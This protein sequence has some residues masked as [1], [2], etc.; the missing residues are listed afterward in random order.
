MKSFHGLS[1]FA[2]ISGFLSFSLLDSLVKAASQWYSALVI[3][4]YLRIYGTLIIILV[5]TTKSIFLRSLQPYTMHHP[6]S[7]I[8]RGLLQVIISFCFSYGFTQLPL[9]MGYSIIF[10]LPIFTALFGAVFLKERISK[11][12]AYAI[13]GGFLGILIVLRPGIVS[14]SWGYVSFFVGVIAEAPF[15]IM[16]QHY[17]KGENPLSVIVYA[18]FISM[19]IFI[20]IAMSAGISIALV[21]P[22]HA[23][24]FIAGSIFYILAQILI[25][26]SLS[27]ISTHV[28]IAM[29]YTQ[30]LWGALFGFLFF[31]ETN[32]FNVF[33][34]LGIVFIIFSSYIV[35]TGTVP[36]VKKK[37]KLKAANE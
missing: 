4:V 15:F 12:S 14:F 3:S 6:H 30:I 35:A 32:A 36:F 8:I 20:I 21:S 28:S 7:H 17:H 25:I 22:W 11:I 19:V 37:K 34:I 23:F 27:H 31:K 5:L 18:S 13:C 26:F 24:I 9:S 16:A 1:I 10:L 2:A 33:F 29:Q